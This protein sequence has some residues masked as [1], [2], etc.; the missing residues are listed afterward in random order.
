MAELREL[1]AGYLEHCRTGDDRFENAAT[2]ITAMTFLSPPDSQWQMVLEA[3]R[4]ARDDKDLGH[5]A[6][7]PIEGLLGRH[8]E[9]YIDLVE[10]QA[11]SD[12]KFARA[13]TGVWRYTMSDT[14]WARVRD[15]QS[16]VLNP[17][18]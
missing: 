8:G 2:A 6:A 18:P 7:G 14:I 16:R 5:I 3:I 4:Q 9:A 17:L 11:A 13:M 10:R 12:P 1:V 15:I